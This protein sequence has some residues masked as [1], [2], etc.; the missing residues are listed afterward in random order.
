VAEAVLLVAV[1]DLALLAYEAAF[2]A[3][4]FTVDKVDFIL[5]VSVAA[6]VA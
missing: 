1:F 5:T 3:L 4:V 6:A 2:E